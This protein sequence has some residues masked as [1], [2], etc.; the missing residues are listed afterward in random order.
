MRKF[1]TLIELLVVIAIIAILAAMLLPALQQARMR[2]K[3]TACIS[4]LKQM[5][6]TA[7]MYMDDHR[8][9]WP[10]GKPD[11]KM[12]DGLCLSKDDEIIAVATSEGQ[13]YT[14][15]LPNMEEGDHFTLTATR[16]NRIRYEYEV[17]IISESGPYV[18]IDQNGVLIENVY[19]VLYNGENAHFGLKLHNYGNDMAEHTTMSLSCESPFIEIT[20][21]TCQCQN[22]APGQTVTV[23]HAFHFNIA[24]IT[25]DRT[26][27]NFTI[28]IDDGNGE[29]EYFFMQHI[30]APLLVVKPDLSLTDSNGQTILQINKEG[31]TDIHVQI[32]NEGHFDSNPVSMQLELLAPF[33]TIDTASRMFNS[34]RKGTINDVV[35]RAYAL[36]N[37]IDEGLLKTTIRLDD[38]IHQATMDTMLPFAGFNESF[39]TGNSTIGEW[40]M[41]GHASWVITDTDAHSGNY[42]ARSG[43]IDHSQ[44]SSISIT[45]TTKETNINFFKK[46]SSENGYDKLY[47]YIDDVE[48]DAWSGTIPWSKEHYPVARGTHTFRW[49]YTKDYSV[50]AGSDCAWID[51][52]SI[53]PSP[54]PIVCFGDTLKACKDGEVRIACGYAYLYQDL[55]WTTLGDG[56]FVDHQALHPI[57]IPGSQDQI[58]GGV[59]LHLN[60]DGEISPL[61]LILTDEISPG[62]SIIGDSFI[63][64][65]ANFFS[66]YSVENQTGI[67]VLWTLEPEEAGHL[68]PHGNAVDIV[69]NT[70]LD[71]TEATLSVSV[72]ASCSL[73]LNKN[74]QLDPTAVNERSSSAFT[75]FPNPTD[76][77]VF[78]RFGQDLQG[79]SVVE[80]YDV[81]G[82]NITN[83]VLQNP[84]KGQIAEI[85]LQHYA[86]GIYIVKLCTSEGCWS[87]K[88]SV[89]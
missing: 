37:A 72:D 63:N 89:N 40:Q 80:V 47:F 19:D 45:K 5:G 88:I 38:G 30:A 73:S 87:Q 52:F 11:W 61:Q 41:S 56:Y 54:T 7:R 4:N 29:K 16:Q 79:K 50:S 1:F 76:G 43:I 27:V 34:L 12:L 42:S 10:S 44:T 35:F 70:G 17:S 85:N 86:P 48:K 75:L 60:V 66:H 64:T 31:Y 81:L 28:H 67:E 14:F 77:K 49:S 53:E 82:V 13:A 18:T 8:E 71:I 20:Q 46:V 21:N 65:G 68:F 36:D 74:I 78:L 69:W 26:E 9:F 57:Y 62:D 22:I 23:D 51:D 39:E 6:T 3:T 32:A 24:D 84:T 33:I 59:T 25:P 58:N 2:A 15:T 55:E 83:K